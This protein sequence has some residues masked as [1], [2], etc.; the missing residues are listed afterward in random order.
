MGE[1]LPAAG[2]AGKESFPIRHRHNRVFPAYGFVGEEARV[3]TGSSEPFTSF[4]GL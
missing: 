3:Q 2:E 1:P 4:F